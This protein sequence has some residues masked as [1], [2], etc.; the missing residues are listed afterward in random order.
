MPIAVWN[1]WPARIA[2]DRRSSASGNCSSNRFN[3]FPF[4]C[5]RNRVGSA[6]ASPATTGAAKNGVTNTRVS[7]NATRA[8]RMLIS[9]MALGVVF[10]PERSISLARFDPALDFASIRS[11]S[12]SGPAVE[13]LTTVESPGNAPPGIIAT[14]CRR[15]FK[16]RAASTPGSD[17]AA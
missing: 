14:S 17:V 15:W 2:R 4:L 6:D 10:T 12:G 11:I 5:T 16:R 9:T 8:N 13:V 1:A 7:R 3:R